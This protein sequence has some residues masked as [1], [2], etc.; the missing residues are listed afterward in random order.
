MQIFNLTECRLFEPFL[1]HKSITARVSA[2]E[3]TFC[4]AGGE[5]RETRVTGVDVEK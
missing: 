4:C 2:F 5:K 1:L 3:V